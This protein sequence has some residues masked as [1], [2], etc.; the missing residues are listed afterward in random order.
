MSERGIDV[1]QVIA[2][3]QARAGGALPPDSPVYLGGAIEASGTKLQVLGDRVAVELHPGLG[4]IGSLFIPDTMKDTRNQTFTRATVV[5]VG[6]KAKSLIVGAVV[7]VSDYFGDEI[8]QNGRRYRVGRERDVVAIVTLKG[9]APLG[10]RL[11]LERIA[12]PTMAGLLYLPDDMRAQQF[13]A[14]VV[15]AGPDATV[16]RGDRVLVAKDSSV[17]VRIDG[18]NLVWVDEPA[19][20]AVL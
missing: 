15:G 17:A 10:D 19:L 6:G 2:D 12:R 8:R 16:K 5:S 9:I 13:E 3:A 1:D 18:K 20:L 7:V 11:L 4:K 14:K